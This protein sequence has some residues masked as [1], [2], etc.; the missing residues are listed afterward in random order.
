MEKPTV[1]Y[2]MTVKR[3]LRYIAGTTD[4]GCH[5]GRKGKANELI[6]YSDSDLAVDVDTHQSTTGVL[7]FLGDSLIIW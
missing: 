3:V 7:F 4:L 2:L 5:F 6:G 1:E